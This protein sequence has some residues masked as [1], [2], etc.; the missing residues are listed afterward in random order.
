MCLQSMVD[1]TDSCFTARE[2]I[3][4]CRPAPTS[5][6]SKA[7]G[8]GPLGE[9]ARRSVDPDRC[10]QAPHKGDFPTL[11]PGRLCLVI[12]L[13]RTSMMDLRARSTPAVSAL[14]HRGR[15]S[16]ATAASASTAQACVRSRTDR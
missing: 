11:L 7:G 13:P 1:P 15:A 12:E 9:Q 3:P 10:R 16:F 2:R 4:V 6:I 5:F 8:K 14:S